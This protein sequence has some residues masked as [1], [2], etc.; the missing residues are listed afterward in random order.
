MIHDYSLV[1]SSS[2]GLFATAG[3]RC[4][5]FK[6]AR[7]QPMPKKLSAHARRRK[8]KFLRFDVEGVLTD[9]KLLLVNC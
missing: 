9:G 3:V 5:K 8:I 2:Q 4:C 7:I 6:T 1:G